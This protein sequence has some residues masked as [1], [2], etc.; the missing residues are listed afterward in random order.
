MLAS[1]SLLAAVAPEAEQVARQALVDAGFDVAVI[2]RL[3]PAAAEFTMI[4]GGERLPIPEWT[5]DEVSR[6]LELTGRDC[7]GA[8]T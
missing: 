3:A 5:T 4:A 6:A 8:R 7:E 2:G 1:G